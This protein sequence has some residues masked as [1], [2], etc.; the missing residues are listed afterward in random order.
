MNRVRI[1]I[2]LFIS[3]ICACLFLGPA[4]AETVWAA[5]ATHTNERSNIALAA[6]PDPNLLSQITSISAGG[7]HTCA[8]TIAGG[9]KCWGENGTAQLGD[10]S[11]NDSSVPVDVVGL[12]SG[13]SAIS[14]GKY[15]TCA[16]TTAGG[17]KCWGWNNDGLLGDGSTTDSNVPVDVVGLTS[18]VSAISAGSSHTCA[19]TAAAGVKCWGDNG[20]GR[21]GDGS[22]T[23]SSVP[24][25]VVGLTS[26]VSAVSA[27]EYHTCA[28]T[29]AGGVKCWGSNSYGQLG[30]GS[31]TGRSGVPVD[32]VGLTSGASAVSAGTSHTCAVTVGGVK[33]WGSNQYG[34]LGDGSTTS[35][36]VP[37]D[38]VGLTSGVSMVSAGVS[39]TCALTLRPT[40]QRINSNKSLSCTC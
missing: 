18:G 20:F 6:Q 40:G 21:L 22:T 11:T 13:V 19:V 31:T 5:N 39:Y 29:A 35:S 14:A 4:Q 23:D 2:S 36:S 28:V 25:D 3:L 24:V 17:V 12:T 15:H 1:R 7:D 8:I 34:Q 16:L 27:D 37:I 26:G 30:D 9:V 10:G 33:C 38:A 32:V